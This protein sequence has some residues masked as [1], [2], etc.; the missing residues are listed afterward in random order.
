MS[1]RWNLLSPQP[2]HVA[3]RAAQRK[4]GPRRCPPWRGR[5]V[6]HGPFL[7]A[8]A[9]RFSAILYGIIRG[10]I[11]GGIH[12]PRPTDSGENS[13]ACR[14]ISHA[15]SLPRVLSGGSFVLGSLTCLR[16]WNRSCFLSVIP[17]RTTSPGDEQRIARKGR[18]N[19][20]GAL[21]KT[22]AAAPCANQRAGASE[23]ARPFRGRRRDSKKNSPDSFPGGTLFARNRPSRRAK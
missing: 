15:L 18:S 21:E 14:K 1:T 11:R 12:H 10:Q 5:P 17:P 3:N 23:G 8:D 19:D 9:T 6:S 20:S 7:T 2:Q 16:K 13:A 22:R 4:R